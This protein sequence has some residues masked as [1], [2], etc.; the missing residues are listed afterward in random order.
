MP[1]DTDVVDEDVE[2]GEL[3]RRLGDR[4]SGSRA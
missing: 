3:P 1:R 4:A 2:A